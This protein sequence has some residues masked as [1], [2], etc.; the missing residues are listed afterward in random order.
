MRLSQLAVLLALSYDCVYDWVRTC[1]L[2]AAKINGTY[3][4][5]PQLAAQWWRDHSTVTAKAPVAARKRPTG[6]FARA[7][8]STAAPAA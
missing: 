8:D 5:D 6:R 4:I 1:D 7:R 2:P 3:W